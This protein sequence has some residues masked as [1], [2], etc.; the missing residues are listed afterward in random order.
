[1]LSETVVYEELI[2]G[3]LQTLP[4]VSR[5]FLQVLGIGFGSK[6]SSEP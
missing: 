2:V 3:A 1:M 4:M 5:D 6:R